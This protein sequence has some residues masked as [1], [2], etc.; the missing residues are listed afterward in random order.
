LSSKAPL[1]GLLDVTKPVTKSIVLDGID[2]RLLSLLAADSRVSQ[3]KLA[4]E[5]HMS[6]PAVGERIARL[7][8]AGVIRGYTVDINWAAL[9]CS[10]VYLTVAA[11][12][13]AA[14]GVLRGLYAIPEVE[15]V[16]VITGSFD[17]LAR[18]RVRDHEHLRRVLMSEIWKIDG[19]QRTETFL[20]L[21]E[22]HDKPQYVG[23][24]LDSLEA[25]DAPPA[26]EAAQEAAR[27]QRRKRP[28]T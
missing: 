1:S 10:V 27:G 11:T 24:V 25:A 18:L 23:D 14:P 16:V 21:G 28:A 3:R 20:G 13:G 17:M 9:G 26:E 12:P 19:L 2:R 22:M 15:D 7:E 5:L 8:R 4:A 6:P